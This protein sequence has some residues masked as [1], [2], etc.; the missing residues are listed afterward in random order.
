MSVDST[1]AQSAANAEQASRL[2]TSGEP[3]DVTS[4]ATPASPE[5]GSDV[6]RAAR[7]AGWAI[8]GIVLA[9]ALAVLIQGFF[10]RQLGT[11]DFGA[12]A[13]LFAFAQ[14][15]GFAGT[16][17]LMPVFPRLVARAGTGVSALVLRSL[18]L[19]LAVTLTFVAASGLGGTHLARIADAPG[20]GPLFVLAALAG[21]AGALVN[22]SIGLFQALEEYRTLFI[23]NAIGLAVSVV[24]LVALGSGATLRE[25]VLVYLGVQW[26]NALLFLL[27]LWK[28]V[29]RRH[30]AATHPPRDTGEVWRAVAPAFVGGAV[31][32]PLPWLANLL[33][34]RHAGLEEAGKFAVAFTLAQ[35]GTLVLTTGLQTLLPVYARRVAETGGRGLGNL[36]AS[37]LRVASLLSI[38]AWLLGAV[39]GPL[40]LV[41][42]FGG[43]YALASLPLSLLLL[44][45]LDLGAGGIV[46][47]V[48]TALGHLG[49]S[50]ASNVFFSLVSA[51]GMLVGARWGASGAAAGMGLGYLAHLAFVLLAGRRWYGVRGTAWSG[52]P[53]A[54]TTAAALVA[55]SEFSTT[56]RIVAALASAAWVAMVTRKLVRE[57]DWPL[58]RALLRIDRRR[59][60]GSSRQSSAS[61]DA[62]QAL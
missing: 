19:S 39:F 58:L 49:V 52:I 55:L 53:A 7:G 18:G 23:R 60:D 31:V 6:A 61:P 20:L 29:R 32:V 56:T 47:H 24:A 59:G 2:A 50:A 11:E 15:V 38:T 16:V 3:S 35:A 13:G 4:S 17:G 48:M 25:A 10:A 44:A 40:G 34:S 5:S 41:L 12:F 9:R 54:F 8:G 22:Q 51:A 28:A 45:A 42:L 46:V 21:T 57:E 27:P 30:L 33:L 62:G 26:V 36:A 37:H 43:E 14:I 1:S